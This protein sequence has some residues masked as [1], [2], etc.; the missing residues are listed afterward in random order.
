MPA[1]AELEAAWL[2]A[3][4]DPATA[5]SS[6]ALLR[7]Y[8]GPP[9]AALPRRA[10]VA[11]PPAG[12]SGSSARTSCTRARTS[13]TTRSARRCSP[14]GWASRG[15]SPRPAPASTASRPRPRARCSASSAS[16]TW[17]PRT[18]AASS[19]TCSAWSCSARRSSRVE[20]G[21][22]TL[23]EAVSEAIRDWVTN[24]GDTHY[25]IGSCVGPAPY[26]ALVRDLQRVIGDEARA[27]LLE[28]ERPAARRASSPASAAARTRSACSSRSSTTPSVEL[29]GVEAAGEGLETRP[30][31]R[32]ADRRRAAPRR[33]ARLL[34]GDH[35]GR[36]GPDHRGALDLGR[37]STTPASGPEHA[38][39]RDSGRAR[40]VAVTDEQA[41]AAF[42][43]SRG[44]RGS[45]RRSSPRT[46]S[47][48]RSRNP[49]ADGPARPDLP[50]RPRRQGPR[51]GAGAPGVTRR[52]RAGHDR[53]RVRR[54]A[55][56]R[57]ALMPYLM[58]GFPDLEASRAIGEAYA[59]AGADL[60]ELGV[61]F[62]DPLAD[63][64]VIHA[65]GTRRSRPGA[66]VAR[67]ARGRPGARRARPGRAHVLR[68]PRP[69]A[70]RRALRRRRSRA[71]GI[72]G[73]IVPD[74]PLEEAG[75]A[76]AACDA[77]RARARPARR[78]D[79]A[80]RAP[81][82][83]RRAARAASS[84]PS[85]SPARPASARRSPRELPAIAR[86]HEGAHRRARRARLRHRHA[87][88]RPRRP[89]TPAPTA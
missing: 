83:D 45:S 40:Y 57:A 75:D 37:A 7:D 34:L 28:R 56:G 17:A 3:R 4:D 33:A 84:T 36:G 69:R 12:R 52:R 29:V 79:D 59:E 24:V 15:S 74:L 78:A 49:P 23:K 6:R 82:R 39:L 1:L 88:R 2:A 11:R 61:P 46:R 30:P 48:G 81:R 25:V 66:T 43:G 77:R 18:S 31:R 35:A 42:R 16:S 62:S 10:P 87:G 67:R 20:A 60:V 73:L 64:P 47:P 68:Q 21:A 58:G 80:R 71:R 19:P 86:A 8:C 41:L 5:P 50:L 65:A 38:W 53:R 14:S 89:P 26:P 9:D 70:R 72:S 63:G 76:L 13:S 44:S 27:Q 55:A 32:A 54:V 51:R 85:R 22:R